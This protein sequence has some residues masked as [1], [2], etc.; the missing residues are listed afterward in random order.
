MG[1]V[2]LQ[3]VNSF[4]INYLLKIEYPPLLLF[5]IQTR[6]LNC[7]HGAQYRSMEKVL[8]IQEGSLPLCPSRSPP[9]SSIEAAETS[10]PELPNTSHGAGV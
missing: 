9:G 8:V 4:K 1:L 10:L 5:Y 3:T 7:P 6:A 2:S